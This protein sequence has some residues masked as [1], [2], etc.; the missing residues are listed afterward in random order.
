MS[1]H[2]ADPAVAIPPT[3][4]FGVSDIDC[5][6]EI[7][8]ENAK[9]VRATMSGIGRQIHD[10]LT[11]PRTIQL[12][13][14]GAKEYASY[15]ALPLPAP[16][17]VSGGLAEALAAR[18]SAAQYS[19]PL[20]AGELATLLHHALAV[21]HHKVPTQLPHLTLRLKPFASG[22][23]LYPVEFYVLTPRVDGVQA[24]VSHYDGRSGSLRVI[25]DGLDPAL[26]NRLMTSPFAAGQ[27]PAAIIF[28]SGVFQRAT[29][30]YGNKGYKFAMIEA[31][32]AGQ[33]VQLVATAMGLKTTFWNAF[34]DD[35]VERLLGI[36][37]V[38]ESVITAVLIGK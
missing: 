36:D 38:T 1:N 20:D 3:T 12:H 35:E 9:F 13:L 7:Y 18:R 24:A 16:R 11:N 10:F 32:A 28:M 37:G 19:A 15:R 5:I 14:S 8:N 21:N 2:I 34:Y 22:G 33:T 23:G 17:A 29:N 30:K 25:R 4:E 6:Y 26:L 31:G 27:E